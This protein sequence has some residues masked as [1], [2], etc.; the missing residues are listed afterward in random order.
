MKKGLSIFLISLTFVLPLSAFAQGGTLGTYCSTALPCA[1]P[2]TCVLGQ[3]TYTGTNTN[4]Q[5][6][7]GTPIKTPSTRCTRNADGSYT[8]SLPAP[9]TVNNVEGVY[10]NMTYDHIM[11][12]TGDAPAQENC[13]NADLG[14]VSIVCLPFLISYSTIGTLLNGL[15]QLAIGLGAIAAVIMLVVG[16]FQYMTQ[17]A[18]GG[19]KEARARIQGAVV[20]LILL[21]LSY[22][23]LFVINDEILKSVDCFEN[24]LKQLDCSGSPLP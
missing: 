2:Y 13:G 10:S 3:C 20:G 19:Q 9:G 6:D 17:D 22:L 12:L 11:E 5:I 14:F 23:I 1:A 18:V 15:F 21:L 8:C 4:I 16:G 7:T 24:R